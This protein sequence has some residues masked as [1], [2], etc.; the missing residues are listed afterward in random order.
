[1]VASGT[2]IKMYD[3]KAARSNICGEQFK[4]VAEYLIR[5][6][7]PLR[8]IECRPEYKA[9]VMGVT[10]WDRLSAWGKDKLEEGFEE[11]ASIQVKLIT[12]EV[13][14]GEVRVFRSSVDEPQTGLRALINGQ[15]HARR[16]KQ[17]FETKA[18]DLEHIAGSMLVT[19]DCS[20]LG[21]HSRNAMFMSNRETF[22]DDPLVSD[23]LKKVQ[24]ELGAHE[25]LRAINRKRYEEK[26]ANATSDDDGIKALE[27]LLATDPALAEL[28][29]R[30]NGATSLEFDLPRG[31]ESRVSFLTDVKNNYF[32]R[33]KHPGKCVFHGPIEPTLRLFNGRLT[34]TFPGNKKLAEGTILVTQVE[35]ADDAG[36][37]PFKLVVKAKVVAPRPKTTHQP[38]KPNPKVDSAASRPEII[39]VT[40]GPNAPPITVE[41][42]PGTKRLLLAVNKDSHLLAEAKKLRPKAEEAAVEFVFKYG[43]ALIAMGLLD[44]AKKTPAWEND[45]VTCREAIQTAAAGVGRVIVPLCLTL[46]K[47][48]PKAA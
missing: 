27:E 42:K 36:H 4:K 21:Q 28:F 26:I 47:K 13:V 1:M 3:Y 32:S 37:G 22:R 44:A 30:A 2:L 10:V 48:L 31:S 20:G 7:L 16:D 40:R 17:F 38:P 46:P 5:P 19:L 35:I 33:G 34:F 43:L 14:P 45:E 41:R 9:K 8:I 18:V 39:E 15:S 12:G 6:A 29:E 24:R 25:G 11:G 23:L